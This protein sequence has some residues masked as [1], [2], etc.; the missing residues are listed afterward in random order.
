MESQKQN[1]TTQVVLIIVL[2][3][4]AIFNVYQWKNHTTTVVTYDTKIDSMIVVRI[5]LERE[6]ATSNVELDKYRGI[7]ANLDTLLNEA[8]H[9]MELQEKKIRSLISKEKDMNSL[10]KKLKVELDELRKMK[11]EYLEKI[12]Q[13]VTENKALKVKN[14]EL[15]TTVTTLSDEKKN[16][17]GKVGVASQL[18]AEYLKVSAFKKKNSGKYVEASLAKKTNKIDVCLTVM[19]NKIAQTGDKMVYLVIKEPTGKILAGISKTAF[20]NEKGEDVD[21]TAS[22]KI[23]YTGEKQN[24]CLTFETEDRNLTSGSYD[25]DIYIEGSRVANTQYLLK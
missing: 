11:D 23:S 8:N 25:I 1:K 6:L 16:L 22:Y 18:K 4:S 20:K 5:D 17:E 21:A 3:L 14:E 24:V 12:D 2:L 13:L 9:K 15:N 19:D 7:S 10:N